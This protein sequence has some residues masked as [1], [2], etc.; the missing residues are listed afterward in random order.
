ME[1]TSLSSNP[2]LSS[3]TCLQNH[4]LKRPMISTKVF[5]M[6][7]SRSEAHDQNCS[8]RLVDVNMIVLRK[9]IHEQKMIERNYEPPEDW[10]EWEKRYYTSYDSIICDVL[11]VL[12]TL[13]MNT[14]PSL[15]LGMLAL[16]MLSVPTSAAV[17][18][19]HLMD[20]TKGVV[21][22]GIHMM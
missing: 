19:F 21:E 11:G 5:A 17:M 16:I 7:R 10:M 20:M 2:F 12:Q 8:G 14:R 3:R 15:A 6:R 1:S 4:H 18:F 9:R 13:L 22:A